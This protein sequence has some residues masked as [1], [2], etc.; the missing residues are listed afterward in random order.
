VRTA[1][2]SDACTPHTNAVVAALM[3]V[4]AFPVPGLLNLIAQDVT[5]VVAARCSSAM[6][7]RIAAGTPSS[8]A[9]DAN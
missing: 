6:I 2:A 3:P 4:A 9:G 7:A 1:R 8:E 5:G